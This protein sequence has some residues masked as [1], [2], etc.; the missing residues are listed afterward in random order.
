MVGGI[1][2]KFFPLHSFHMLQADVVKISMYIGYVHHLLSKWIKC[3][4]L[5]EVSNFILNTAQHLLLNVQLKNRCSTVSTIIAEDAV[6]I[7]V[8]I[9]VSSTKHVLRVNLVSQ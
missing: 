4:R 7:A 8:H 1:L 3:S 9:V 6:I 5:S 2:L